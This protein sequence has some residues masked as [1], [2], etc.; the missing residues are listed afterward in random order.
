MA[1]ARPW[2][3]PHVQTLVGYLTRPKASPYRRRERVVLPDGDFIDVDDTLEARPE[4]VGPIAIVL[5][6]LEGS[7]GSGYARLV[8]TLLHG[9][10]ARVFALNFRSCSGEPNLRPRLYHS[11]DTA[12]F[13]YLLEHLH[14]RFPSRSFVAVG[15]SLGG[16]VLLK[17][18]GERG[19][20]SGLAR[21]AAVSVPFNLGVSA[22]ALAQGF[23]ELYSRTLLR[24]LQAKVRGRIAELKPHCDPERGLKAR[25]FWEF[26]DAVTGPLHGFQGAADYFTRASSGPFISRIR[27]PTLLFQAADDPF[28]PARTIPWAAA[29]ASGCVTLDVRA[30]G[31]HVGFVGDAPWRNVDAFV[32]EQ[33][34][35]EFLV[36]GLPSL[37][38]R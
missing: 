33:A 4:P 16:N 24:S 31:G 34:T 5:H 6:G 17:Y 36:P 18:L 9:R 13:A 21:A 27:T 35:A 38:P 8:S 12:D 11:G 25:N 7:S 23:T 2:N 20:A 1:S 15:F 37:S 26:D 32:A 14:G 30:H 3:N 28:V 29:H 10:G 19:D 22:H